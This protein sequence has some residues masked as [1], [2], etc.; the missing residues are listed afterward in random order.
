VNPNLKVQ[1]H[2]GYYDLATPFFQGVYEMEHL[3]DGERF[4]SR[5]S[6]IALL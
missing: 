3:A 2:A 6:S 5:T 4:C 1:L